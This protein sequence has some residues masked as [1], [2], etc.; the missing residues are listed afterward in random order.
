[1]TAL[2]RELRQ[3]IALRRALGTRLQEPAATLD[4]I[5]RR[6]P[7]DC[8]A[9]VRN[10]VQDQRVEAPAE[11]ALPAGRHGGEVCLHRG[12]DRSVAARARVTCS[13]ARKA[14][15]VDWRYLQTLGTEEARS[16]ARWPERKRKRQND[17]SAVA[18]SRTYSADRL[19]VCAMTKS[20]IE[21][22]FRDCGK[23]RPAILEARRARTSGK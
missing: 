12:V 10:G 7:F 5:E 21:R 14:G 11:V 8:L 22:A 1:M 18:S 23:P 13:G 3:Y 19:R 6:V 2:R 17:R 9:H 4:A 16:T 20:R 15:G